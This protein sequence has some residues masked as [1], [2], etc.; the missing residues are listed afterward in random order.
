LFN[1]VPPDNRFKKGDLIAAKLNVPAGHQAEV[2]AQ[3][4]GYYEQFV[5]VLSSFQD[6]LKKKGHSSADLHIGEDVCQLDMV[7]CASPHWGPQWLGGTMGSEYTI[8][9]NCV[10][11]NAW[12]MKQLVQTKPAVLFLVGEASYNMFLKAF[13]KLIKSNPA[14]PKKPADGAFTLL[15]ATTD[16]HTP[17][18]FE[19][20]ATVDGIAY[21]LATRLVITPH[22]SYNTN[23]L[24]QFRMSGHDWDDFQKEFAEC[25]NFLQH[26]A[27]ITVVP[28]PSASEFG[29]IEITKDAPQVL[30]EIQKK[31]ASAWPTLAKLYYDAHQMMASVLEDLYHK[32]QITFT[33]PHGKHPGF[34]TRTDGPCSFCVNKHWEFPLGCP[35]NKPE[36]KQLPVGYL[37]KVTHEI[38]KVGGVPIDQSKMHEIRPMPGPLS[39][40]V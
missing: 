3:Q 30:E 23:F 15:R 18:I 5:P 38:V 11:K 10:A 35:Y 13:G 16:P 26:D 40:K 20:S 17:C 27:R 1:P 31:Y 12:A 9:D 6:F 7:A 28:A 8:I 32:K 22:F 39:G 36:E 29:A 4:I 25:A 33:D 2:F 19:F 34:L 21:K 14:L 37:E 24:P